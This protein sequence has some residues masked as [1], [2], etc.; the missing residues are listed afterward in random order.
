MMILLQR[1]CFIARNLYALVNL[2]CFCVNDLET[3]TVAGLL[4]FTNSCFN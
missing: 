1:S 3:L 2:F 4:D